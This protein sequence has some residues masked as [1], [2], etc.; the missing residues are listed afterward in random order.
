MKK[1]KLI[2]LT[3]VAL[4]VTSCQK[5]L[6]IVP[7]NI[8]TIDYAF[9]MRITAQ[10][11]LFT[12]YSFMPKMAD[13]YA[14]PGMFGSDELWLSANKNWWGNWQLALGTQNVNN[15]V[16]D[17]WNGA[18]N[19]TALWQGI[20][21]CNIF[22]DN[23]DKVPDMDDMEKDQWRAEAEFLKA[24][25]HFFLLRMYGPIPVIDKNLPISASGEEVRVFRQPIDEV[26]GYIVTTLDKAAG[27]LPMQVRDQN[28]ELGRITKPIAVSL[29]AKVLVYAA[30]P[31]FNG[32]T[33]YSGFGNKDGAKL[34][35]A[36]ADPKKWE[37]AAKA[38]KEA[39]DLCHEAGY[40]LYEF[41]VTQQTRN[42]SEETRIQLNNRGTLTER[43][44]PEII[45]ANTQSGTRDLQVWSAPRVLETSHVGNAEPNGSI[46]VTM[47]MADLFYSENGV[48]I[49]EDRQ[50]PYGER[51]K[52]KT[53]KAADKFK[54][55]EGYTTA[56]INF[57]RESRYYG[58]LGFDG[59]VWYGQGR[60]DDKDPYYLQIKKEQIGGK[61]DIGW[62]AVTGIYAKKYINISNTSV[63]HSTYTSINWPWVMLRLGDLYLMYAE[64]LNEL[65]GPNDEAFTYLDKI[66]AKAGLS[67]VKNS[68]TNFSKVPQK[69]ST[70][71]GLRSIIHRERSIEMAF[72]GERF[73]DLR[74]WKEASTGFN[75]A[76]T[77]WDVD[78]SSSENYYRKRILFN[79][80][81]N[82]RDYFWPLRES[83]LIVNKNLVQNPGW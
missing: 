43:W 60:F 28:S 58:S 49:E 76:I 36:A 3:A 53:S 67:G 80:A 5:Y 82:S 78:Q 54:V 74:R 35:S 9:R 29:K 16:L 52:L 56:T 19:A 33:D 71:E 8:A 15:P 41:E 17:Y 75:T 68:W 83:D 37:V 39:I 24:Y 63:N 69:Y 66:R 1:L 73:W 32:N 44:N 13:M 7:D 79:M 46:G 25:Y 61:I 72:E 45:W 77:G 38:C 47:N 23:I 57:N 27:K 21:Q 70:K 20:S 2:L 22:L 30:S 40:K 6:D 18:N 50:Y 62:H 51:Y 31:L 26:F 4:S 64:A 10:K 42:I 65:Q 48:P 81:F 34:F 11:Y 14:S 55:K 59:G 12:C